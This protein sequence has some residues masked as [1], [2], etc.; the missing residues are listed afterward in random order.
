[1]IVLK[2]SFSWDDGS[3]Y[4]IKVA[5]LFE[6]YEIPCKL[7]VP[8][9]NVEGRDVLSPIEIKQMHS[10]YI[11]FGGHTENHVYLDSVSL[12][13]ALQEV[14]NNKKYLE[15]ILGTEI[16]DFC[17]P[18]G[19]YTPKLLHVLREDFKTVRT[20]QTGCSAFNG[21]IRRPF[22]HFYPRGCKS[23]I[24]NAIRNLDK[25]VVTLFRTYLKEQNYF[26]MLELFLC[27]AV[28][29]GQLYELH[30]WGHSWEIEENGLWN[31]LECLLKKIK[32]LYA[33]SITEYGDDGLWK[34]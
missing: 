25:S 17:F 7:F 22:F 14:R 5:E 23:L 32:K 26:D 10:P 34:K 9:R 12:E 31:R 19:K 21:Y 6:K 33:D 13:I 2:V 3:P 27:I 1:M 4:D 24:L 16:T 18:G 8:N 30:I 15:D 29:R 20:A 28:E 11:S